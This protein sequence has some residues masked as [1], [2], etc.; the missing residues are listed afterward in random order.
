MSIHLKKDFPFLLVLLLALAVHFSGINVPFFTDDPGL[1]G[2]LA[3]NMVLK[4]NYWELFSYG[5]D[6]LDK[7]HFPFWMAALS[8]KLFGISTWS[9]KLPALLFFLLSAVYTYVFA[10]KIYDQKTALIAVLILLSA[11]H[12]FMSNTDVRAE[13]YLMGLIIGSVYHFYLLE[14]RFSWIDLLLGALFAA[15]AVMTKGIFALI[16]IGASVIGELIFK[17][18][19]AEMLRLKWLLAILLTAVFLLPEIYSLYVQFDSQP[20]KTTFNNTH[21]SGIQWFLWDSQFGRFINSGPITRKSGSVFFYVHTLIWAFAPWFFMLIYAV[22]INLKKIVQ[23]Q[24]LKEYFSLCAAL[25]M[26]LIFSLSRFQLSFYTNI[27]F[28]FFAIMIAAALRNVLSKS[29]LTYFKTAQLIQV[30]LLFLAILA[31]NYFLHPGNEVLFLGEVIGFI[32]LVLYLY[33]KTS[34]FAF[35]FLLS[36][37]ATIFVNFYLNSIF[38]PLLVSYKADAQAPIYINKNFPGKHVYVIDSLSNPFQ[39][40]CKMPVQLLSKAELQDG[41]SVKK[42]LYTNE[43]GLKELQQNHPVKILKAVTNYPQERIF[44]DFIW[45]KKRSETLDQYYIIEY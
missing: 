8:F 36:C 20:G 24:P 26:W 19:Y 5:K 21:I 45:Y 23:K 6:W 4:G 41:E 34:G 33:K 7:P 29:A 43:S 14:K 39:F 2:S 15:C 10:K 28:P 18:R 44:K 13:P 1:Y 42:I 12:V 9:Y 32:I 3:K 11:Q 25:S 37:A 22:F 27:I 35:V 38:Y 30:G 40:Y 31:F 17:K 16:P